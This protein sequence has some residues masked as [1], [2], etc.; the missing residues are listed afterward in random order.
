MPCQKL[1]VIKNTEFY[2][3]VNRSEKMENISLNIILMVNHIS[4]IAGDWSLRINC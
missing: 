1:D 4:F 3:E 2:D